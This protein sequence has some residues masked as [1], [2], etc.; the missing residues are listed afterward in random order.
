MKHITGFLLSLLNND[1]IFYE[2]F[3]ILQAMKRNLQNILILSFI[4]CSLAVS[5]AY[6][7]TDA[8]ASSTL[9]TGTTSSQVEISFPI[10]KDDF[11][12]F[13]G[14]TKDPET[15]TKINELRKEFT[16]KFQ[17]LKADY[18]KSF[19][20]LVGDAALSPLTST[21]GVTEVKPAANTKTLKAPIK[22]LK[23]VTTDT[24]KKYSIDDTVDKNVVSPIVNAINNQAPIHTENSSWFQK[25]KSFFNW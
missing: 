5:F 8:S 11:L 9:N 18:Q 3:A 20:N 1:F 21:D 6:A 14:T 23:T 16:S 12:L 10:E 2:V 15:N 7:E 13:Y 17:A 25:V 4:A 22:T 19:I 24:V